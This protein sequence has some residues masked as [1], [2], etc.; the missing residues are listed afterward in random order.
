MSL[1]NSY[2]GYDDVNVLVHPKGDES[3]TIYPKEFVE[4]IHKLTRTHFIHPVAIIN[5]LLNTP[6]VLEHRKKLLAV[7]DRLFERQLRSKQ[8]NEVGFLNILLLFECWS[9]IDLLNV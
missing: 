2:I 3:D 9:N 8:P 1:I 5:S 7:V 6:F 4:Y